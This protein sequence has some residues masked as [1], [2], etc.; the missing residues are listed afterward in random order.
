MG[1]PVPTAAQCCS[2][3]VVYAQA[4][5]QYVS[6]QVYDLLFCFADPRINYS[7]AQWS[8]VVLPHIY[9]L[10]RIEY[11]HML[12]TAVL[13]ALAYKEEGRFRRHASVI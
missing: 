5:V 7:T 13:C 10:S 11:A 9:A 12:Y 1:F 2:D 3:K 6:T 8:I 4:V